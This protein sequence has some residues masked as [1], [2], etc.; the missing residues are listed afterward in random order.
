[1]A[2]QDRRI[3]RTLQLLRDALIDLSLERG[4][5]SV[6]IRDITDRANLGRATFYLHFRDKDELLLS[7][8][9]ETVDELYEQIDPEINAMFKHGDITA[10]QLVFQHAA[11]HRN[12]YQIILRRRGVGSVEHELRDYV[13]GKAEKHIEDVLRGRTS[14]YPIKLSSYVV[15]QA[16][17]GTLEWWLENNMLYPADYMARAFYELAMVGSFKAMGLNVISSDDTD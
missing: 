17:L 1:M 2:H 13:A 15:A 7:I 3:N 4:Y 12:L 10:L 14:P 8:L 6:T 5:D 16:L 11:E 9:R